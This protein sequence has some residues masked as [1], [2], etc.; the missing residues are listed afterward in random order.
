MWTQVG[1]GGINGNSLNALLCVRTLGGK[2]KY[3]NND[4]HLIF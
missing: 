4:L 2:G 3:P 1:G